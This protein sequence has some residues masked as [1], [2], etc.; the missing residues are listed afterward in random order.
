MRATRR[1]HYGPKGETSTI[2][3]HK[4]ND[5][6]QWGVANY[7]YYASDHQNHMHETYTY[8]L[9]STGKKC[10]VI[11]ESKNRDCSPPYFL[12]FFHLKVYSTSI[13]NQIQ[14]LLAAFAVVL[15]PHH[16]P[17]TSVLSTE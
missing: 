10:G 9:A 16:D 3:A 11:D 12:R 5:T 2:S 8:I 17:A 4:C 14:L 7:K 6:D 13:V 15:A 1:C